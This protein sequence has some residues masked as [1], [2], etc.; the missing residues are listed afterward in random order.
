LVV[1]RRAQLATG[2][3]DELHPLAVPLSQFLFT[4]MLARV[5]PDEAGQDKTYRLEKVAVGLGANVEG[6][7]RIISSAT[8]AELGADLDFSERLILGRGEKRL[9]K[10]TRV[11]CSR[12]AMIVDTPALFA[13]GQEH[14]EAVVRYTFVVHPRTGQLVTLVWRIDLD[15]AGARTHASGPAVRI[16]PNLIVTCPVHVDGGEVFAGIPTSKAFAVLGLPTGQEISLPETMRPI[17]GQT[18]FSDGSFGQVEESLRQMAG[19]IS[20]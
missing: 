6:R 9:D 8:Q 20:K 13:D 1:K 15:D 7:D 4:A 17:A 10:V 16:E 19:L 11:A 3:V 5:V 18:R 2:D 14:R 12:T